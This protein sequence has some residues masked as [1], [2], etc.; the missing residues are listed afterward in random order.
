METRGGPEGRHRADGT[1]CCGKR[2][3]R[4]SARPSLPPDSPRRLVGIPQALE[5]SLVAKRIHALPKTLV[6]EGGEPPFASESFERIELQA[7]V[8]PIDVAKDLRLEHEEP[9]V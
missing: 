9:A 6:P 5:E 3:R 1:Q 2:S 8:V 7:A 4:V